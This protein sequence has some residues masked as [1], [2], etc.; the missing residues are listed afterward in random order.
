MFPLS[1]ELASSNNVV[2]A[3]MSEVEETP[4]KSVL[5][6]C[7]F[8]ISARHWMTTKMNDESEVLYTHQIACICSGRAGS[9]SAIR[10]LASLMGAEERTSPFM[11][12]SRCC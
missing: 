12:V 11:A 7:F 1:A 8:R 3:V 2:G 4:L 5:P 9:V 10:V 6:Y